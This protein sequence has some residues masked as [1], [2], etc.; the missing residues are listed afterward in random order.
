MRNRSSNLFAT[1]WNKRNRNPI[2]SFFSFLVELTRIYSTLF[3]HARSVIV[4]EIFSHPCE[5]CE[6]FFPVGEEDFSSRVARTARLWNG[7]G[8]ISFTHKFLHFV[9]FYIRKRKGEGKKMLKI[10]NQGSNFV[11][12]LSYELISKI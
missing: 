12:P 3:V 10:Q 1:R 2:K 6:K 11:Y 9:K 8:L 5:N 7:R 4:Y